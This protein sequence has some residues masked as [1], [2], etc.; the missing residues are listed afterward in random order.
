MVSDFNQYQFTHGTLSTDF[1]LDG[2]N[3]FLS[4]IASL[5]DHDRI[6]GSFDQLI[7]S[8]AQNLPPSADPAV[9]ANSLADKPYCSFATA[10]AG[11]RLGMMTSNLEALRSVAASDLDPSSVPTPKVPRGL[12]LPSAIASRAS[13]GD[14]LARTLNHGEDDGAAAMAVGTVGFAMM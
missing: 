12:M 1:D 9:V 8:A 13:Q 5:S 2:T 10:Y 6:H 7:E 4:Y 14:A 11:A 3:E